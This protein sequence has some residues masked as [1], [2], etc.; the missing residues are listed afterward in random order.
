MINIFFFLYVKYLLTKCKLINFKHNKLLKNYIIKF[1][2]LNKTF[3]LKINILKKNFLKFKTV[4][5]NKIFI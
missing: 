4:K 5:L 3:F 1:K 2:N